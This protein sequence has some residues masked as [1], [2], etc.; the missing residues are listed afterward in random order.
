MNAKRV[1]RLYD[2]EQSEGAQRGAEED[3]AA[4]AGGVIAGQRVLINVG[5]PTSSAT[6]WPMA[7][8]TAS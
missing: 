6:S 4:A 7:A 5:Q 1:Y 8:P 2:E 3:R